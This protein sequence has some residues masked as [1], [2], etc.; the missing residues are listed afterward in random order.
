MI[1]KK[2]L[3][4]LINDYNYNDTNKILTIIFL[5]NFEDFWAKDNEYGHI[6]ASTWVLNQNRNKALLT[7]HK[8]LNK[9][10][11]LGGHIEKSDNTIFEAGKR[12]LI[13][14]SGLKNIKLI[15]ES[16]FDIDIHK[17]P[18]KGDIQEHFHFDIRMLFEADE[19][20]DIN[21]DLNESNNINWISFDEIINHN[22]EESILRMINKSI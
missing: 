13:E 6:T 1:N 16:I 10:I 17:I 18:S 11:Q 9:W 5:N 15:N 7:H 14:E 20:E 8:K 2:D 3:I 21:Y 22:K 12:E 4:K 19:N